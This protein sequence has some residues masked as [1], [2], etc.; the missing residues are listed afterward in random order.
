[1][2]ILC[3][4]SRPKLYLGPR[5]NSHADGG[6]P[7]ATEVGVKTW[8]NHGAAADFEVLLGAGGGTQ[9]FK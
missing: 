5:Q 7:E 1:M 2:S 8:Q 6:E 9:S 3:A 4:Q